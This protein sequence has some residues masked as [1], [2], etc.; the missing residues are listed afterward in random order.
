MRSSEANGPETE[1]TEK[2]KS[3]LRFATRLVLLYCG[4]GMS[5]I[6]VSFSSLLFGCFVGEIE[7]QQQGAC[8]SG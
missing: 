7:R 5:C 8:V 2:T 3:T 1:E 4:V 6:A